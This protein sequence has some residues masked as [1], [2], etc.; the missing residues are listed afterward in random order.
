MSSGS[1]TVVQGLAAFGWR[2]WLAALAGVLVTLL[3]LAIPTDIIENPLFVRMTPV[4]AQDY[5][6]WIASSLLGGLILGSYAASGVTH[7]KSMA[8]GGFLSFLAIGC[9]VCNK[10]VLLLLGTSGALTIFAPL[11]LYLG[12]VA[13]ALLVW[14]LSLRLNAV[15]GSCGIRT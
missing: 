8:S 15:A 5:G 9:P 7:E 11:Q 2:G 6:I 12:L 3:V 14:T 4:R 13:V 1:P 10:L